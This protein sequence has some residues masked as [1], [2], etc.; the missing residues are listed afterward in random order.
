VVGGPALLDESFTTSSGT[1]FRGDAVKA[2]RTGDKAALFQC[3]VVVLELHPLHELCSIGARPSCGGEDE[4]RRG[5]WLGG[6]SSS[7][8]LLGLLS[9]SF[10]QKIGLIIGP[11]FVYLPWRRNHLVKHY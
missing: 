6:R 8:S 7:D 5:G 11:S 9:T 1:N 2:N 10:I 3:S 4:R